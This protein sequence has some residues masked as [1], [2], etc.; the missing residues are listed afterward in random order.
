LALAVFLD[1]QGLFDLGTRL[2][3]EVNYENE[4]IVKVQGH[5]VNLVGLS[6]AKDGE[7]MEFNRGGGDPGHGTGTLNSLTNAAEILWHQLV[8]KKYD[9]YEMKLAIDE[10]KV[11]R[12]LLGSEYA[13]NSFLNSPTKI[14]VNKKFINK[15]T[16]KYS[17]M[18]LN[19]YKNISS[20]KY[21]FHLSEKAN[22]IF[23]PQG[24]QGGYIAPWTTLTHRDLSANK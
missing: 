1:D 24:G 10:D 16:G 13:A 14:T 20:V 7:I 11:P 6:I 15:R 22:R 5:A 12:F 8:Q 19:Y 23:R 4:K 21:D 9:L 2:L 18:A 17:E 3:F